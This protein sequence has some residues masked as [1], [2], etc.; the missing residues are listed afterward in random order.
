MCPPEWRTANFNLIFYNLKS[1]KI[2]LVK[3]HTPAKNLFARGKKF[4][5]LQYIMYLNYYWLWTVIMSLAIEPNCIWRTSCIQYILSLLYFVLIKRNPVHCAYSQCWARVMF[6]TRHG[7]KQSL[8]FTSIDASWTF[9]FMC[10]LFFSSKVF[11]KST[12]VELVL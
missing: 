10:L 2:V 1:S 3:K 7:A 6:L 9:G 8:F 4:P 12:C 5:H 11:T